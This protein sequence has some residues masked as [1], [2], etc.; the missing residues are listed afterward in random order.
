MDLR[1]RGDVGTDQAEG[2]H[3]PVEV[4]GAVPA[5]QGQQFSQ[6]RFVDLDDADARRFEIRNLIGQRQ[7]DLVGGDPQVDIVADE[8]PRQD[9]HRTGEHA[10][11]RTRGAGRGVTRPADGDRLGT[12][13][14]PEEDRRA[15]A[16]RPVGLHPSVLGSCEAV[17]VLGEVLDHIVA[18][19][20]PVDEDV[21]TQLLL[22]TDDPVDLGP[23]R[24]L[25][26]GVIE[27]SGTVIGPRPT[28]LGRL[29]ERTD[30]RRRQIRDPQCLL[31]SDPCGGISA[32]AVIGRLGGGAGSHLGVVNPGRRSACA[33]DTIGSVERL[34]SGHGTVGESRGQSLD[35]GHL[36][37]GEGQPGSDIDGQR[38]LL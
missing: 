24:L 6:R 23:H 13:H 33:P 7:T 18:F 16:P 1:L 4:L 9:R 3:R 25:I 29:R 14:V 26:G 38:S 15:S 36:L 35:F 34:R 27:T 20:F 5:A 19:G 11:D 21:E 31:G 30:G 32:E 10:L 8:R 17:E 12:G 37:L 28:H 22:Q 2:T